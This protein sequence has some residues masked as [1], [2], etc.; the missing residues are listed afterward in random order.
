MPKADKAEKNHLQR[1]RGLIPK[2]KPIPKPPNE[3]CVRNA[4]A[5][6]NKSS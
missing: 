6:E 4:T 1:V 5:N 3:A 2:K